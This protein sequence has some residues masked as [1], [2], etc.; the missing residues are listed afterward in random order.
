MAT[1]VKDF[2]SFPELIAE[3]TQNINKR[4][5]Y[6][7]INQELFPG[8]EGLMFVRRPKGSG[9]SSSKKTKVT[10]FNSIELEICLCFYSSPIGRKVYSLYPSCSFLGDC[11]PSKKLID[12]QNG[13]KPK[14]IRQLPELLAEYHGDMIIRL[15]SLTQNESPVAGLEGSL[16][17]KGL[18]TSPIEVTVFYSSITYECLC[19]YK[20]DNTI[21]YSSSKHC[22]SFKECNPSNT[23]INLE[24]VTKQTRRIKI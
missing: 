19:R 21:A 6:F 20:L 14:R 24:P 2:K 13:T 7:F 15:A 16:L 11:V 12:A 9:T 22:G 5:A 10:L 1:L 4:K 18:N 23:L 8:L 3:S 17:I